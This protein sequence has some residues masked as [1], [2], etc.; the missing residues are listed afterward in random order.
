[1]N[2]FEGLVEFMAVIE[3]G[4]FS[5]AA[6]RLGAS[7]AHVSRHVAALERRLGT[8]LFARTTRRMKPTT[9]GEHLAFASIPL[10]EEL[11]R[12]QE[13]ILMSSEALEGDIRLSMTGQFAEEQVVPQLARFCAVHPRVRIDVD[14]SSQQVDLFDGW[15]DFALRMAPLE[16]S[17]AL[18][19]RRLAEIPMATLASAALVARLEDEIG[20][21]LS[22]MTVPENRCLP[23]AGRPWRFHRDK[24]TCVIEPAGPFSSNSSHALINAAAIGLGLIHVPAY[25]VRYACRTR[26]LMPVFD[27]W[28]TDDAIECN[29][30]YARNRFMPSRVRLLIDYLLSCDFSDA[31]MANAASCR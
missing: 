30:V 28:H 22:P 6:R 7:V 23:L 12:I 27:D 9:A 2:R 5:S 11:E 17:T 31:G 15:F 24:Q 21:A 29:I 18:V 25:Y 10:L 8:K 1:M 26:Q 16:N 13:S 4:S 20:A 14:L 3:A 19:A